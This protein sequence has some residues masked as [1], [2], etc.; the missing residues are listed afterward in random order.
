MH[1]VYIFGEEWR[2]RIILSKGSE[3]TAVKLTIFYL[4]FAFSTRRNLYFLLKAFS[5]IYESE[6]RSYAAVVL[7]KI[8]R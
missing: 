6:L 4:G 7:Q 5:G 3:Y 2:I 8:G 1:L